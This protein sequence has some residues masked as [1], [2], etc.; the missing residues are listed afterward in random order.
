MLREG[1]AIGAITVLRGQ[2]RPFTDKEIALLQDLRRPGRHRDRERAPVQR[3]QGGARAADRDRRDPA[4]HQPARRPTC[5]RCSTRSPSAPCGCAARSAVSCAVDGDTCIWSP[6]AARRP[7]AEV[8]RARFRCRST[9]ARSGARDPRARAGQMPDVAGRP[10]VRAATRARSRAAIAA[11]LGVP[12]L[13]EGRR[14]RRSASGAG[15]PGAFP[16]SRSRCCRPS[17]TR[18]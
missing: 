2:P 18:P 13:R 10:R 9:A 7:S 12:M 4:G 6:S 16:T 5:S 15:E 1:A 11:M 17:P 14:R 8:M 3:D